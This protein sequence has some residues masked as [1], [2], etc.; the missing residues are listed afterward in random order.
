MRRLLLCALAASALVLSAS[1]A[2]DPAAPA[3]TDTEVAARASALEV[4]GAFSNS[5]F[6]IRDGHALAAIGPKAP[7]FFQ[8]NL[9][10][11]NQYWFVAAAGGPAKKIAVTVFDEKG[12]FVPTELYENNAQAAAGFS[13]QASG[14]YIIRV[15]ELDGE[16]ATVCLLYCYK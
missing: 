5:G 3:P 16:P 11:G 9:Y 14:S 1:A 2:P 10:S 8:V 12:K 6:K 4:A 15:Q 13:P 7:Q